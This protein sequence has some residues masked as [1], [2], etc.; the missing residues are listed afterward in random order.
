MN[1]LITGMLIFY[2]VHLLS[3]TPLKG[4]L[5]G[6]LGEKGYKGLFSLVALAG[7]GIMIWGFILTGSGPDAARI[8]YNPPDWGYNVVPFFVLAGLICLAV[9]HLRGRLRRWLKNPMSIG[10]A[11]WAGGHLFANGNLG[12][13]LFFGGF[14]AFALLDIIVSTM[15]G[16][17]PDYELKP[18][19]D[20][21]GPIAG[22]IL[23]AV[24]LYLHPYLFGVH[25]Y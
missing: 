7:L 9:S 14:L 15:R 4:A 1:T 23:F 12:E 19:H 3:Y 2:G 25:P 20:I 24:I 6:R 8:V 16:K 21:T 11:L 5:Q 10:I 22:V 18:R 13:V 17:K